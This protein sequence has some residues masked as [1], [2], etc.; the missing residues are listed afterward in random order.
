MTRSSSRLRWTVFAS[1]AVAVVTACAAWVSW[2]QILLIVYARRLED[3]RRDVAERVEAVEAI[4]GLRLAAGAK[5]LARSLDG[6][7]P[8]REVIL[9]GLFELGR[10]G[11]AALFEN[12]LELSH[13]LQA[14]VMREL[15]EHQIALDPSGYQWVL[16]CA[17][18]MPEGFPET[19]DWRR[20]NE[21]GEFWIDVLAPLLE[22][23]APFGLEPVEAALIGPDLP[24]RRNALLFTRSI[25]PPAVEC[26]D[27][28]ERLAAGGVEMALDSLSAIGPRAAGAFI[29]LLDAPPG[30]TPAWVDGFLELGR[31]P[32]EHRPRLLQVLRDWAAGD[33]ASPRLRS[34]HIRLAGFVAD[35]S[36]FDATLY[37]AL[38]PVLAVPSCVAAGILQICEDHAIENEAYAVRVLELLEPTLRWV[39]EPSTRSGCEES[40][41]EE[42][43]RVLVRFPVDEPA[44]V[45]S[46]RGRLHKIPSAHFETLLGHLVV[47][48]WNL[49]ELVPLPEL[50]SLDAAVRGRLVRIHAAGWPA[51]RG[52]LETLSGS[53]K[54][55]ERVFARDSLRLAEE[56]HPETFESAKE[57]D[58]ATASET[59][60]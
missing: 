25:G 56:L 60:L 37:S 15:V 7:A 9:D 41:L 36:R 16:R 21:A 50:D 18:G 6:P 35:S 26:I 53:S 47:L 55:A 10:P 40:L 3:T 30:L 13:G 20:G 12:S 14:E 19:A 5:V 42:L 23:A 27:E 17:L 11:R 52:R 45:E 24:A 32:P 44:I 4:R 39:V 34:E 48:G 51:T 28:L 22:A 54:T 58:R 38:D 46:L 31:W 8:L 43:A 33:F 29:R 1:L 57:T 49:D 59:S 2:D